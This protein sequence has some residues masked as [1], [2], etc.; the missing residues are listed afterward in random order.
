MLVRAMK[1]PPAGLAEEQASASRNTRA[2]SASLLCQLGNYKE[3]TSAVPDVIR[4]LETEKEGIVRGLELGYFEMPIQTM[5][6][7]DKAALLP[8]LIRS[9]QANDMSERNNALVALQ[10]YQNQKETVVPL[11]LN[12]LQDP[13]PVVRR[14]AGKALDKIDP[15]NSGAPAR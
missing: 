8:E 7:K 13:D 10:Y 14:M 4:L 12:A 9:M 15:Q 3:D 5:S 2:R 6:E 11:I 1:P